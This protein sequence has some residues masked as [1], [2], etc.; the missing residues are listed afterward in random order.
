MHSKSRSARARHS[1][2]ACQRKAVLREYLRRVAKKLLSAEGPRVEGAD[3]VLI[4]T[5]E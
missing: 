4:D 5:E 3:A 1:R 2:R